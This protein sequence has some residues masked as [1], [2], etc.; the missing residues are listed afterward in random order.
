MSENYIFQYFE[1]L[2][3]GKKVYYSLCPK[4]NLIHNFQLI[5]LNNNSKCSNLK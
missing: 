2:T 4:N 5:K 3:E 1:A